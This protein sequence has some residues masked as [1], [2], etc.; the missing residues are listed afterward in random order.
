MRALLAQIPGHRVFNRSFFDPLAEHGIELFMPQAETAYPPEE[1]LVRWLDGVAAWFALSER[2]TRSVMQQ[3]PELKIVQRLGTGYDNVDVQ[4]ATELGVLVGRTPGANA[5]AVA[6]LAFALMMAFV[7]HIPWHF[8]DMKAGLWHPAERVDLYGATL[9]IIGLGAIGREV[10]LRALAFGMRVL[11]HD[12][13]PD[14][15]FARQHGIVLTDL[16][17]L[18]SAA[19]FVTLHLPLNDR[20]RGVIG[21]QA[22]AAMKPG[23]YLINTARGPLIDEPAVCRA[24]TQGRLAGYAADVFARTPTAAGDPLMQ[25][26]AVVPTPWVGSHSRLGNRGM[27]VM[28]VD[29]VVKALTGQPVPDACVVNPEVLPHWRGAPKP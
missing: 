23:A 10:A 4:A 14:Q 21:K 25:I 20:T 13:R 9:G 27:V 1:V 29:C 22:L 12:P 7:G 26:D 19:D 16:A 11:A 8:R 3:A 18:L 24:L 28:A 15:A 6:E 2:V 17:S 5:G